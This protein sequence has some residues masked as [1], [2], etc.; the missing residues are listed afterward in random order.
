MVEI[1]LLALL[2][3]S[4]LIPVAVFGYSSFTKWQKNICGRLMKIEHKLGIDHGEN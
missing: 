3:N 4:V 2:L 1:E